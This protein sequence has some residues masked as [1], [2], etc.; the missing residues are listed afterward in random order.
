M[1]VLDDHVY[2]FDEF[3]L[4]ADQRLLV[5]RGE[6]LT[7]TPRVFD[8]LLYFV[9]HHNRVITK[10]ELMR[11]IWADS[12]VEENNLSQNVS[13]LRRALG[14]ARYI[15]TV[16]GSGYRF[17]AEVKTI[18]RAKAA[19]PIKKAQART[20]AVLPFKP[21]VEAS[22]DEALEL[23]MADTLIA[24]LSSSGKLIVRPL[25]SVRRY[26]GL[27]QDP[28]AA[29]RELGVE[30]LLDGSLQR[31]ADRIRL[32]A[33]LINVED[34]S[35][36]WAGTFDE[37]A[38]DVFAVQDAISERV[39]SAL[40]VPL[41]NEER[42]RLTNRSTE[43]L[44]AYDLYLKGRY[45]WNKLISTEVRRS[46]Q[47]FRKAID[48]DP[49]YALAYAGI[50]EA[51]RSL[52]ISSDVQPDDSFPLAHAAVAKALEIDDKL[53]DVHATLSILNSWYDWDWS[54]AEREA[55]RAIE[56]NPNSSEAH[57]A[58]ALLLSTLGRQ[59]EA[60]EA[61]A[62]AREFDPLALLTRTHESLFLYYDGRYEEARE[63]LVK[64]LEIESTFWIALLTLAKIYVR[65]ELYSDA[66]TEL[67]KARVSS[68]GNTQTIAWIGYAFARSGD[69]K[70]ARAILEELVAISVKRYVPP[71]NIALIHNGLG[72]DKAA[73]DWLEQAYSVRD[74]LLSAFITVDP[75]WDRLRETPRLRAILRGMNLERSDEGSY[76]VWPSSSRPD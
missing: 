32:T 7:L 66:I 50:A 38:T 24:R 13:T 16:P 20:I 39:A 37:K 15:L 42:Q 4:D 46:I 8:T 59:R 23:G 57:R 12:F 35:S 58:N 21:I 29:G 54:G 17:A 72:E 47:F 18:R 60:I 64:T 69:H 74:V 55:K 43:N 33:R 22:R 71:H 44:E 41:S 31:S 25:S 5:R 6:Q 49:T 3:R 30:S 27:E 45:H 2:E 62:Q 63:K 56:L 10:D 14:K 1:S 53:A 61:A 34:G 73:L 11:A 36:M 48:I 67:S 28:Q 65:Q 9:Q 68:G 19:L 51:Y 26:G 76:N 70:Q 75:S 52:P 40:A